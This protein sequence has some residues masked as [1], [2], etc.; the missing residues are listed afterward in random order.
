MI[1]NARRLASCNDS[2]GVTLPIMCRTLGRGHETTGLNCRGAEVSETL[3]SASTDSLPFAP[4]RKANP[5][6]LAVMPF[7]L[8]WAVRWL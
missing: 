1:I 4:S 7:G 6:N 5:D 3:N 2:T 8:E